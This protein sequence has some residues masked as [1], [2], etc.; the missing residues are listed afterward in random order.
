MIENERDDER[1]DEMRE[2][3]RGGQ[4]ALKEPLLG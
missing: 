3:S 1:E 2:K 4:A